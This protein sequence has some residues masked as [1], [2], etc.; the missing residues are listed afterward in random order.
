MY[1]DIYIYV[2]IYIYIYI[3]ITKL[4]LYDSKKIKSKRTKFEI[5]KIPLYNLVRIVLLNFLP[6]ILKNKDLKPP[7]NPLVKEIIRYNNTN[8]LNDL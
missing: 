7:K 2:Y 1:K 3:C 6:T 5:N 4:H 8:L